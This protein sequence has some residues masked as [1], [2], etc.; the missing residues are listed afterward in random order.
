MTAAETRQQLATLG[1]DLLA[2]AS[3][4]GGRRAAAL[5]RCMVGTETAPPQWSDLALVPDWLRLPASARRA[6]A[7]RVALLSMARALAASI[8]GA[9]LG[10]LAEKVGEAT[11]EW[12]IELAEA[13]P[14]TDLPPVGA[15]QLDARGTALLADALPQSLRVYLCAE[16]TTIACAADVRDALI[17]RA[18]AS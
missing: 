12:A 16:V 9:W 5:H 11:L 6:L 7:D 4:A 3:H 10:A 17:A 14:T 15:D 13:V 1:R 18:V 8:D 2:A